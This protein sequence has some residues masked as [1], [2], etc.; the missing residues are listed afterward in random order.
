[1][2]LATG[3]SGSMQVSPGS[4]RSAGERARQ[5]SQAITKLVPEVSPAGAPA[6]SAHA[7]WQFGTALAAMVPRWEQHLR[8]QAAAVSA[9]GSRLTGSATAYTTAEDGLVAHV[10]AISGRV[11]R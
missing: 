9:A 11:S 2:E 7:G 6:A 4:L 8:Q 1:M 5:I 3:G 10:G